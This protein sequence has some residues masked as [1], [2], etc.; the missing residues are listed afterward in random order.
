MKTTILVSSYLVL[1]THSN[2][3]RK[4]KKIEEEGG[5][6]GNRKKGERGKEVREK[7]EKGERGKRGVAKYTEGSHCVV[8]HELLHLIQQT[9]K[10]VTRNSLQRV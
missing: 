8:S 9:Y 6:W 2:S 10:I 7:M 3:R 5:R 1:S 4:R